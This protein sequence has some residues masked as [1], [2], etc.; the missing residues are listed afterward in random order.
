MDD[1]IAYLLAVAAC[2]ASAMLL[3]AAALVL[4]LLGALEGASALGPTMQAI[5]GVGVGVLAFRRAVRGA[6]EP[7]LSHPRTDAPIV[8]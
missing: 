3:K 2:V 4:G 8:R 6:A 1:F 7:A 5:I